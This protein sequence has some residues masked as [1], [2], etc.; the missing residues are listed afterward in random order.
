MEKLLHTEDPSLKKE[1]G[2]HKKK[3]NWATQKIKFLFVTDQSREGLNPLF[4]ILKKK[5]LL[6]FFFDYQLLKEHNFD[7]FTI[8]LKFI[9]GKFNSGI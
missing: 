9:N 2:K 8:D 3:W 1:S 5:K 6:I 7:T 4:F